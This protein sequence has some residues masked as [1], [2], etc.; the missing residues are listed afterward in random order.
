MAAQVNQ[1]GCEFS[2]YLRVLWENL[3]AAAGLY[4]KPLLLL[5][6]KQAARPGPTRLSLRTTLGSGGAASI[7]YCDR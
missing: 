3:N 1:T 6:D 4:Y 5:V 2:R 7:D